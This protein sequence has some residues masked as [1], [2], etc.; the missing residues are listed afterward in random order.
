MLPLV[1]SFVTGSSLSLTPLDCAVVLLLAWL[2]HGFMQFACWAVK[3]TPKKGLIAA[4]FAFGIYVL[5]AYILPLVHRIIAG[6]QISLFTSL[7]IRVSSGISPPLFIHNSLFLLL[8]I[9]ITN[10]GSFLFGSI[11]KSNGGRPGHLNTERKKEETSSCTPAVNV[12]ALSDIAAL[13]QTI[14]QQPTSS[15][16]CISTPETSPNF[17][18]F[19]KEALAPIIASIEKLNQ[20][21]DEISATL[22]IMPS[23]ML[24]TECCNNVFERCEDIADD[25]CCVKSVIKAWPLPPTP[26]TATPPST[27]TTIITPVPILPPQVSEVHPAALV[28]TV[29]N[30]VEEI[31][32]VDEVALNLEEQ[33]FVKTASTAPLRP[34]KVRRPKVTHFADQGPMEPEFYSEIKG[35]TEA[36]VLDKLRER[37]AKRRADSRPPAYLTPEE[38]KMSM[39]QLF[40]KWKVER[41]RIR[42]EHEALQAADFAPLGE[43]TEDQKLLPRSQVARIVNNRKNQV[44]AQSM[45]ERGI[46]VLKCNVCS[47]LYTEDRQ[48]RCMVTHWNTDGRP[49]AAIS[50]NLVLSQSPQGIRLRSTA[51]VDEAKVAREHQRLQAMKED[52]DAKQR[53][54][55]ANPHYQSVAA[56]TPMPTSN[57]SFRSRSASASVT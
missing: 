1:P 35:L 44:W 53:I 36:E 37:E 30:A 28:T 10:F 42:Q 17:A 8:L 22:N 11:S 47:R 2:G 9:I 33:V 4:S 45:Q 23:A 7:A 38:K 18:R 32:D 39:D 50:R 19:I 24:V 3:P 51:V 41:Q 43:L 31:S 16:S 14:Y 6:I 25:L 29:S 55:D 27:T 12:L 46:K 57:Y 49:N 56:D 21:V 20:R 52:M 40:R 48:H 5:F 15:P 54:V 13:F 26:I 34:N